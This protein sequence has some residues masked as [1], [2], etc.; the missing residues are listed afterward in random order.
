MLHSRGRVMS[1]ST[2]RIRIV[3]SV[4]HFL[5]V[6]SCITVY[7]K[8][9]R[10]GQVGTVAWC[11]C[12]CLFPP[13]LPPMF[14]CQTTFVV[15]VG[16]SLQTLLLAS[17]NL[18]TLD[19]IQLNQVH[20]GLT[21]ICQDLLRYWTHCAVMSFLDNWCQAG[22][23]LHLFHRIMYRVVNYLKSL[24]QACPLFIFDEELWCAPSHN[25]GDHYSM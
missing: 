18:G 25:W 3:D 19:R 20:V 4:R 5:S 17:L 2:L 14:S 21:Q 8:Q 23:I 1:D 9:H 24:N 7:C 22:T 6:H 13:V 16:G 12:A 11:Y 10:R 15:F